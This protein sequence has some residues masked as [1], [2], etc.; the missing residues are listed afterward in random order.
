MLRTVLGDND[1]FFSD[2]VRIPG[3][4]FYDVMNQCLNVP[5]CWDNLEVNAVHIQEGCP[6]AL[7][8]DNDDIGLLSGFYLCFG[9][10]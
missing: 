8:D 3:D 7:F 6:T 9:S 1:F 10:G 2:M 4:D 5:T